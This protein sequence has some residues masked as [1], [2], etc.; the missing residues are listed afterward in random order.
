MTI[1]FRGDLAFFRRPRG[2]F[3]YIKQKPQLHLVERR[4]GERNMSRLESRR[5]LKPCGM[6]VHPAEILSPAIL[7]SASPSQIP[8][9]DLP[10]AKMAQRYSGPV[11]RR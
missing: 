1:F 4:S 9:C 7:P 6:P 10:L 8:G 11:Q 5:L 3:G 2:C